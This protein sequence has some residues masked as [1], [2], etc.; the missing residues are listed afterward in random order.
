VPDKL[1]ELRYEL[2][3]ANRILANENVF[4]AFGHVSLRHP[5]DPNR[6]LLSRSRAPQLVEPGDILEFT[7]DSKPVTPPTVQLY[8]ERVIHGEIFKARPDVMAVCH[9][10][11]PAIMPFC[12]AGEE[13]V[14]VYHLGATMGAKVPFWDSRD[15]FGDTALVVVDPAEGQSLA[16]ALGPHAMVLMGRH[17]ATVVATSLRELVFRTIYTTRNAELQ[18]QAK[19]VGTVNRL[20]PEEIKKAAAYNLRPAPMERAWD[21]WAMRLARK[22]GR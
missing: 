20:S 5:E 22:E 10:H 1:A 21:L 6:Y 16:R 12:I 15:E 3:L 17:G 9:H 2:A 14:P 7:L 18:T 11:A 19:L 4:D 13:I 8:S